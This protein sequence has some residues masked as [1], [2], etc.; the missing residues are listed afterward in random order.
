V[1][2]VACRQFKSRVVLSLVALV[3]ICFIIAPFFT[4]DV[5]AQEAVAHDVATVV[6][7]VDPSVAKFVVMAA[8]VAFAFGALGAGIAIAYV[9]S[10]AVA[11]VGEKPEIAGQA[12]IFV[13]LAEGIVVFGFITALMILGKA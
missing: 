3:A 5:L 1:D 4:T 7:P 6:Q 12:L 9:G 8:A 11:A 13:A 10:S 2:I